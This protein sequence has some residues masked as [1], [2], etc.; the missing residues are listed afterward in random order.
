DPL[1]L[2]V[3][4]GL[5]FVAAACCE[6]ECCDAEG[7]DEVFW[8]HTTQ[9]TRWTQL[10]LLG[11]LFSMNPLEELRTIAKYISTDHARRVPA[12][13]R[14]RDKG[15]TWEQIAEAL[16]MSRAGVIKLYNSEQQ[17]SEPQAIQKFYPRPVVTQLPWP[18]VVFC[19]ACH[20]AGS[21]AERLNKNS[22]D[23]NGRA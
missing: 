22:P 9:S 15:E 2:L 5:R 8:F 1:G 23:Q 4:A 14:A 16:N 19:A 3:F 17:D 12:I 10:C 21:Y 20:V 18:C 11:R 7:G 13:Q 6:C